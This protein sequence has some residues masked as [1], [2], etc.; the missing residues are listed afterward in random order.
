MKDVLQSYFCRKDN[1]KKEKIKALRE[2][3]KRVTLGPDSLPSIC[4]YTLL[5]GA[6][7]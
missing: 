2:L 4:F 1:D 5:N 7:G 6:N 3:S